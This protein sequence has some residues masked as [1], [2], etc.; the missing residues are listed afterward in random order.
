LRA[1]S[2]CPISTTIFP[3]RPQ[4]GE[5]RN[6]YLAHIKAMFKLAG[7]TDPSGRAARVFASKQKWQRSTRRASNPRMFTRLSVGTGPIFRRKRPVWTG[8]R[9]LEEAG[10]NEAPVLIVSH[11]TAVAR[12][13]ALCVKAPLDRWRDSR[14][15]SNLCRTDC[16]RRS[17][18]RD[19]M[20]SATLWRPRPYGYL[21]FAFSSVATAP[22][23]SHPSTAEVDRGP[24]V[25]RKASPRATPKVS[26]SYP[27]R[28]HSHLGCRSRS[29][30]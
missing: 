9:P 13:S 21:Q 24:P 14:I 4:M 15:E 19:P 20:A 22:A 23:R 1:V 11:P 2:G 10:L 8:R 27:F 26:I 17:G 30:A 25:A 12:L 6:K 28:S 7:P 29:R 3:K 18:V 5:L 16:L